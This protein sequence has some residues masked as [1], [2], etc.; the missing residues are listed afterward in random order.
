MQKDGDVIVLIEQDGISIG[1][2]DT[3][4]PKD[5]SAQVEFCVSG[6][7]SRNTL[8]ALR[9]LF[10]AMEKDNTENPIVVK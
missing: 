4:N 7:R 5:R 6:G 2:V 3:G 9:N 10:E 1:S 8:M